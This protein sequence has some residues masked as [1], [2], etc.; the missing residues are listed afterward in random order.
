MTEIIGQGEV[1]LIQIL[2]ELFPR[3]IIKKQVKLRDLL[4]GDFKKTMS[5]RE[6]KETVDV[7]L[8]R[9]GETICFRVMGR[10]HL[11]SMKS[12]I[13]K[14]QKRILEMNKCKVLDLWYYESKELF[15]DRNNL[16]SR[17][18][19]KEILKENKIII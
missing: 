4:K 9:K 12:N 10:D 11:G 7:V 8:Y 18:E 14:I 1:T 16:N 17:E 15:R 2:L 5:L 3:D 13:D 6:E 19:V